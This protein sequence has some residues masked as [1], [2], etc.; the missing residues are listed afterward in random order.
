M[1]IIPVKSLLPAQRV[2]PASK[3]INQSAVYLDLYP[4]RHQNQIV[5]TIRKADESE[6]KYGPNGK[7]LSNTKRPALIDLYA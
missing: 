1:N 3:P 6:G 5:F 2:I 7:K 4:K